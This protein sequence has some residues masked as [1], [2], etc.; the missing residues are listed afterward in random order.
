MGLERSEG[1]EWV[2][3]GGHT[4]WPSEGYNPEV[5]GN[6]KGASEVPPNYAARN[7]ALVRA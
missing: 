3:V 2:P 1:D 7:F 6:L 4:L 5:I